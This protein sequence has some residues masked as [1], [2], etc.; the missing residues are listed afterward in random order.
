[1][2][3][4]RI[5][6][7]PE[8][9][10]VYVDTY[11][12]DS[13][14]VLRDAILVIPGGGYRYVCHGKEG[15]EIALAYLAAGY[16][17]FVLNYRVGDGDAPYPT[18]LIDA[19][20]AILHIRANAEKYNVNPARVF[21]IGF[22][23][24]GHL[25]GS[26]AIMSDEPEVLAALGIKEGENRPDG[27]VLAYPVVTAMTDTHSD[28]FARLSGKPFSEITLAERERLSLECRVGPRSAPAFIWH[29]A[30]DTTVPPY[31][32]LMLASAYLRAGVTTAMHLYPYGPH[33]IGLGTTVTAESHVHIQPLAV[34]WFGESVKWLKSL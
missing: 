10:E 24:G 19:S 4:E 16:N 21:A 11:I 27:V 32:S 25:A 8:H 18:Q 3:H 6:L 31:G 5:Y 29:T 20:R 9:G 26:L 23:A 7:D 17:A 28:S 34:G 15:E 22:S 2:K 14:N 30:G 13:K 12:S 33:G 1:M